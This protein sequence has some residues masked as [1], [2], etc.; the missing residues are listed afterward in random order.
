MPGNIASFR[1]RLFFLRRHR[2]GNRRLLGRRSGLCRRPCFR[3]DLLE[4]RRPRARP[5]FLRY[6][7]VAVG[8]FAVTGL[9][10]HFHYLII[11][12]TRDRVVQQEP[13]ARTIIVYRV[14]EAR[15]WFNHGC[16]PAGRPWCEGD[17]ASEAIITRTPQKSNPPAL[18][19]TRS[20]HLRPYLNLPVECPPLATPNSGY[21]PGLRTTLPSGVR[22]RSRSHRGNAGLPGSGE[23]G[24]LAEPFQEKSAD[25][26]GP[27]GLA[28]QNAGFSLRS[29]CRRMC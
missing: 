10:D 20:P 18:R 1:C 15:D 29:R 24:M 8:M 23:F 3:Q 19:G 5:L 27:D 9:A 13:A 14:T 6:L 4:K 26:K 12:Q 21:S 2:V 22:R 25:F 11:D 7:R 17:L 28:M 16:I